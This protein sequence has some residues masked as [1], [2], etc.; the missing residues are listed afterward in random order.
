MRE[1]GQVAHERPREPLPRPPRLPPDAPAAAR[2]W[3]DADDAAVVAYAQAAWAP[4]GR[5]I[6]AFHRA[7]RLADEAERLW[8]AAIRAV[9]PPSSPGPAP[10]PAADPPPPAPPALGDPPTQEVIMDTSTWT[11]LRL[12]VPTGRG[13]PQRFGSVRR[14]LRRGRFYGVPAREVQFV[15]D[16]LVLE[17]TD[18]GRA[19]RLARL[20][21]WTLD[22][23]DAPAGRAGPPEASAPVPML[24]DAPVPPTRPACKPTRTRRIAGGPAAVLDIPLRQWVHDLV[25]RVVGADLALAQLDQ[26]LQ[27]QQLLLEVVR[28][29]AEAGRALA[30]VLASIEGC[31]GGRT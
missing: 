25:G 2:A 10:V 5:L 28:G 3:A 8:P 1:H 27:E 7:S 23:E 9:A 11:C 31:D 21:G 6:P 14:F 17:T 26:V 24:T 18:P 20:K 22:D 13:A 15:G 12:V 4:A 30:G 19:I 29:G 16:F